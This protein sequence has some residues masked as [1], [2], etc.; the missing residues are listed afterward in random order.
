MGHS[1][2]DIPRVNRRGYIHQIHKILINHMIL[3]NPPMRAR[4]NHTR[5]SPQIHLDAGW[6]QVDRLMSRGENHILTARISRPGQP[7]SLFWVEL[8]VK[9]YK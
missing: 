1:I 8:A 6:T 4:G 2:V 9:E 5:T 3:I 7:V